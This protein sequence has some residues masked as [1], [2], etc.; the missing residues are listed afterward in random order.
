MGLAFCLGVIL[1]GVL[2]IIRPSPTIVE[3]IGAVVLAYNVG[4]LI[5][6]AF[7]FLGIVLRARRL[8]MVG[9]VLVAV[10][11]LVHGSLILIVAG[12][13]ADQTATRI[14]ISTFSC[15]SWAGC[16]WQRGL[17]MRDVSRIDELS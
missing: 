12:P 4:M 15:L 1:V 16:R 14:L 17:S 7:A 8:E 11:T 3:A 6:G 10:L 5:A 13:Q 2:G 9:L